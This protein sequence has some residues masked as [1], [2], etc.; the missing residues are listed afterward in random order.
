[1]TPAEARTLAPG[2]RIRLRPLAASPYRRERD[3][4]RVVKVLVDRGMVE[5]VIEDGYSFVPEEIE[6]VRNDP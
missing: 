3:T 1:M 2:D 4:F 5:V 6:R